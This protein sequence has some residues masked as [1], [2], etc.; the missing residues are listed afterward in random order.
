M[1]ENLLKEMLSKSGYTQQ[2]IMAKAKE[3]GISAAEQK[4]LFITKFLIKMIPA[5][6]IWAI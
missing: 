5:L 3:L 6:I 4:K 2:E 1:A